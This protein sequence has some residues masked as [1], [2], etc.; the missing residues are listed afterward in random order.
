[1]VAHLALGIDAARP[2]AGVTALVVEAGQVL[3][4][5]LVDGA[6]KFATVPRVA[7]VGREAL[8]HALAAHGQGRL[9]VGAA[10]VRLARVPWRTLLA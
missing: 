3:R 10:R 7:K 4:T 6:L 5:V 8:A 1:M 2:H 9:G